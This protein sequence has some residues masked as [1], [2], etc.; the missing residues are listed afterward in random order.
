MAEEKG[1][2]KKYLL[3]P[4]ITLIIGTIAGGAGLEYI[5]PYIAKFKPPEISDATK[6][7]SLTGNAITIVDTL[8][9][10]NTSISVSDLEKLKTILSD[11]KQS[12]INLEATVKN[13]QQYYLNSKNFAIGADFYLPV[14]GGLTVGSGDAV[15]GVADKYLSSSTM[16]SARLNGRSMVM[17]P[18]DVFPFE[19]NGRGNC[20][21]GYVGTV[22]GTDL[23]GFV[24]RCGLKKP[25][26]E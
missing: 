14:G 23:Y 20:N 8:I 26:K 16:I 5:K 11:S 4:L 3:F 7:V 12:T 17:S 24:V 25:S 9:Q 1:I 13:I 6:I 10:N 18:G 22:P 2:F 21:V 19:S 15:F